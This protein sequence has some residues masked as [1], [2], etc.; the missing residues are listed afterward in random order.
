MTGSSPEAAI[1]ML[2]RQHE[3]Y[4]LG[5]GE[6]IWVSKEM[7]RS[8]APVDSIQSQVLGEPV[9]VVVLLGIQALDVLHVGRGRQHNVSGR[10][11]LC[12]RHISCFGVRRV[13][14]RIRKSTN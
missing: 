1:L 8:Q 9:V 11:I 3:R 14:G 7:E 2:T 5:S 13:H 6:R 12:A 4:S 10:C